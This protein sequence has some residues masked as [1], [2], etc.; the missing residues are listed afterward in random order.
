M[1]DNN[2]IIINSSEKELIDYAIKKKEL[3]LFKKIIPCLIEKQITPEQIRD[4]L[5]E[6]ENNQG[7]RASDAKAKVTE[8]FLHSLRKNYHI[9]I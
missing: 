6:L 9:T 2:K 5:Y 4:C 3:I 1:E 7:Y 8:V